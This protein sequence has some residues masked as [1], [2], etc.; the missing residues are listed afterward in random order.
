MSSEMTHTRLVAVNDYRDT[1]I[2]QMMLRVMLATAPGLVVSTL[3]FGWGT[4]V[5]VLLAALFCLLAE[6]ICLR[7]RRRA[8]RS[9]L[10]DGS[11]AVSGIL[12]GLCLPPL[13][14][15]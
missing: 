14:P 9:S 3:F 1:G 12:L 15:V 2:R 11:A 4:L 10:L 7:L 8:M 6:A 13:L 5:N